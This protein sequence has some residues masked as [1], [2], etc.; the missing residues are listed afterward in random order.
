MEEKIISVIVPVY[1]IERY[2][3][4]CIESII[5]QTY[6]N[7]DIILV[8]DGSTDRSGALCD[9]YAKKDARIRVIH[10]ANGGLVSARKAGIKIAKGYYVGNVDGDD[11]LH[12]NFFKS[13][14]DS[15][16]YNKADL[17]VAGFSRVLFDSVQKLYSNIGDGVYTGE[18]LNGLKSRFISDGEFYR[19]GITTYLWNKLFI[20][21]K[22]LNYQLEIDDSIS[23]GEDAAVVY[24][25]IADCNKI[26]VINNTDYHYRQRED[27]M[28][29]T[30]KPFIGEVAG[31]KLLYG[32]LDSKLD[33]FGFDYKKQ[34]VDY[35]LS[36]C[37]IRSGG[38]TNEYMPYNKNFKNSNLIIYGAGTFGQ[39]IYRRI[40]E[41]NFCNI[42]GWC[43]PDYKEYRRCC[44]DVDDLDYVIGLSYDYILI[45][46]VDGKQCEGFKKIL[47]EKGVDE[48]KILLLDVSR[49]NR[50]EILN[51]YIG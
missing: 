21:E 30:T 50:L 40:T 43:D 12:D 15:I 27:S 29:K 42:V 39:Q 46:S 10:K 28:L 41:N 20:R 4:Q 14:Y 18:N 24:P 48:E 2:V 31:L 26:V 8:D 9:L 22:L 49:C 35:V 7:L 25:Y 5:N 38:V 17:V 45:A 47:T 11:Y 33:S 6:K 3:G 34:I 36:I 37:I 23:I 13:L 1:N 16:E 51:R 32:Y 19:N 44:L